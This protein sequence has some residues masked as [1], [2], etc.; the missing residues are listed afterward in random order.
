MDV[1]QLPHLNAALNALSAGL[2]TAGYWAVRTRRLHLHKR[3]MISAMVVSAAFL[4]S[5]LFYHFGVELTR[6]YTGA[7]RTLYFI[8]LISHVIGAMVNL[9]M[10][11]ATAYRALTAQFDRHRRIARW[12]LPLWWYVSVTGVIVYVMLY[13]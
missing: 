8:V 4:T 2:L 11:I 7:Y 5:Y 9:P 10:V 13:H 6:K 12:T 3:L 1:S